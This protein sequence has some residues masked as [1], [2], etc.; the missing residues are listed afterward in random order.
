MRGIA[1]LRCFWLI[2]IL[3]ASVGAKGCPTQ[4]GCGVS[5]SVGGGAQ[6]FSADTWSCQVGLQ[7][8]KG[9]S[10]TTPG[11]A[12]T[13][14]LAKKDETAVQVASLRDQFKRGDSAFGFGGKDDGTH[15]AQVDNQLKAATENLQRLDAQVS[16][17]D[18]LQP[19]QGA[20]VLADGTWT[21]QGDKAIFQTQAP[22]EP[23]KAYVIPYVLRSEQ[24][25]VVETGFLPVES[26][27]VES[28]R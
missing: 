1:S 18:H 27:Q 6:R 26:I 19:P 28:S 24:G 4:V 9:V 11:Q 2:F 15:A 7:I 14:L 22:Y 3:L 17:L 20:T 23:G 25:E 5:G 21:V 8:A 12:R 13:D 16:A 10:V